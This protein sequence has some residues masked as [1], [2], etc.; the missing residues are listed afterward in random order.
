MDGKSD[1]VSRKTIVSKH[2]IRG[3]KS[4]DV[5]FFIASI[6]A[7]W[8]SKQNVHREAFYENISKPFGGKFIFEC[9]LNSSFDILK[10]CKTYT[11]LRDI[12]IPWFSI[13]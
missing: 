2:N 7:C 8:V 11:F 12:L 10:I 9:H 5:K 6:E 1:K 4:K 13:V 3:L